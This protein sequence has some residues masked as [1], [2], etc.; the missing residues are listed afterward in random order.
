MAR[1]SIRRIPVQ[2]DPDASEHRIQSKLIGIL[3]PLLKPDYIPL[4]IPNGGMRHPIVGK[5]L[6]AEGLLPGSPDLVFPLHGGFV[7]WLE[8][9]N[10]TGSLSDAQLGMRARLLRLGHLWGCAE[11]VDEALEYL[12]GVGVLR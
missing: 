2:N 10:R 3:P 1:R 6:R 11:S 8:M 12:N 9:K 7:A 5:Q 4:A